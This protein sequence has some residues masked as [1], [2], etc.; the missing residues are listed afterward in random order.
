M[1]ENKGLLKTKDAAERQMLKIAQDCINSKKFASYFFSSHFYKPFAPFHQELHEMSDQERFLAIAAPR[2]HAK[3]TGFTFL[4]PM[5]GVAYRLNKFILIVSDTYE[6]ACLFL[7]DVI[8]EFE[9]NTTFTR[10]YNLEI[11]KKRDDRIVIND[12]CMIRAMGAGQKFRGLKFRHYRPDLIICHSKGSKIWE[13]GQLVKIEDSSFKKK[14]VK[15]SLISVKVQGI[16]YEEKVT[17]DHRFMCVEK[18]KHYGKGSHR[19]DRNGVWKFKEKGWC[20][21]INLTKNHWIGSKIDYE[22]MEPEPIKKYKGGKITSRDKK[23]RVVKGSEVTPVYEKVIPDYF[24]SDEFYYFLGR[25]MG[26]GATGKNPVVCFNKK[27]EDGINR[28]VD[29]WKSV[30]KPCSVQEQ[31][32]TK[33]VCASDHA[34]GRWL[35]SWSE[36]NSI[37]IPPMWVRKQSKKRI[38][39]FI[40]GYIDSDGWV[41]KKS[42]QIR[43]TSV[44]YEGLLIIQQMLSRINIPSYIR[45]GAGPRLETFSSKKYGDRT[46]R[47]RQKY[48]ILISHKGN[49]VLGYDIVEPSRYKI[50]GCFIKD[51]FLWKKVAS[52][53][54]EKELGWA[55]PVTTDSGT[56]E[57]PLGLSHNCDDIENDEMVENPKRREKL[58]KWF[59]GALKPMLSDKGRLVVIGTILHEDSLLANLLNDPLFFSKLYQIIGDDYKPLWP[60]L[61]SLEDIAEM[62]NNFEKRNQLGTFYREFFNACVSPENKKFDLAWIKY[63]NLKDIERP[64]MLE[65]WFRMIHVDLAHDDEKGEEDNAYNALVATAY[66]ADNDRRYFLEVARFKEEFDEIVKKLFEMVDFWKPH[67]VSVET[68][69]AQKHF[70]QHIRSE[71][72]IRGKRFILLPLPHTRAKDPRILIMQYPMQIGKYYFRRGHMNEFEKELAAF[73][74]STY[75][76]VEDAASQIEECLDKLNLVKTPRKASTR[77]KPSQKKLKTYRRGARR[78]TGGRHGCTGY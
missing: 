43:I 7:E 19:T 57:S 70:Y 46:S 62:R 25:W 67:A 27:D 36:G 72:R 34:L 18:Y 38:V 24:N 71:M 37:K 65:S 66:D 59:W 1:S 30:N 13:N 32:N 39:K 4:K 73:P 29:F 48:D 74:R 33:V 41:D 40:Q 20:E 17:P 60:A 58:R 11:T 47:S 6:Q 53:A 35:K 63:F 51:G 15:S 28:I 50:H 44:N 14:Q 52:C 56:Y 61:Y 49:S 26:D 22:I 2:G 42:N 64:G 45:K 78:I 68:V 9:K 54:K 3:S 5:K 75:K 8:N 77:N 23:G 76:D 21:A 10:F 16:P 55:I 31:E 69:G 12:E